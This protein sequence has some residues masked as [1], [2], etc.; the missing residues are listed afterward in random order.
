MAIYKYREYLSINN[1]LKFYFKEF[2]M[3]KI[4]LLLVMLVAT[5][6]L[7]AQKNTMKFAYG[8]STD[9]VSIPLTDKSLQSN[10]TTVFVSVY[11]IE[12]LH[13][14]VG[15]G[16]NLLRKESSQRYQ[17]LP[18]MMLGA[19]YT[20]FNKGVMTNEVLLSVSNAFQ[21]FS[22]F[23][24]YHA[25]LSTRFKIFDAFFIGAGV[26]YQHQTAKDLLLSTVDGA[27]VFMELGLQLYIGKNP[28]LTK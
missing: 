2:V 27:T 12:N 17:V 9:V 14:K 23:S 28:K 19:G 18:E 5:L 25:D 7:S 4:N 24:D 1:L 20:V 13:F 22:A 15:V 11:P 6:F 8:I 16:E 26:R 10:L 3:R 21:G